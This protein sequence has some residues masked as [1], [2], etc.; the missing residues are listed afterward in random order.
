MRAALF[1]KDRQEKDAFINEFLSRCGCDVALYVYPRN[2]KREKFDVS[3]LLSVSYEDLTK[4]PQ[5]LHI[6]SV[7][8]PSS[9]VILENPSRY[10]KITS[11]KVDY[12]QRLTMSVE[13]KAL[14]DIVPFT[15]NIQY[16]YTPFSYLG[17]DILGHA[18]YYAFRENY[19]EMGEDGQ[20]HSAHDYDILARKIATVSDISYPHFMRSRRLVECQTVPDEQAQYWELRN[21]LFETEKSPIRIVTQLADLVH[22]FKSRKA[23]LLE[24]LASL[25]GNTIVYTNLL[26]YAK[27]IMKRCQ[28]AG[29]G[30][31]TAT[32]YKTGQPESDTGMFQA[33]RPQHEYNNV[34][35]LES[36]IAKSY[37]YLDA[38]SLQ[39]DGC[40]VF[41]FLGDT[42]VDKYLHGKIQDELTQIDRLTQELWNV[43]Q[44]QNIPAKGGR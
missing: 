13:H 8:G 14:V 40:N 16:L 23:V 15:L 1:S 18:H 20:I 39:D 19:F 22:A 31:V 5:W 41:H 3:G 7:I 6:N 10:P 32:S 4:T 28:K 35:Y 12:L 36:P 9:A 42:K 26:S 27:D 37:F 21:R 30:N 38:E 29:I 34:V 44:K 17:R 11:R 43:K 2:R 33:L 24:L 25:N